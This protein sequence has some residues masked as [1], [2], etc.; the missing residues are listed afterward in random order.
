VK[1]Y[2]PL[3]EQRIVVTAIKRAWL[4]IAAFEI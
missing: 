3:A 2:R 4:V 1:T